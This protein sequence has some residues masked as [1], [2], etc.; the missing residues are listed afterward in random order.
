I[1][2]KTEPSVQPKVLCI[3]VSFSKQC[4]HDPCTKPQ[5]CTVGFISRADLRASLKTPFE[6][7]T[8]MHVICFVNLPWSAKARL[9]KLSLQLPH[10]SVFSLIKRVF[11]DAL[12]LKTSV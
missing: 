7:K 10:L 4:R 8:A 2:N 3:Y 11:R 5:T 9:R 1:Q 12:K 6:K